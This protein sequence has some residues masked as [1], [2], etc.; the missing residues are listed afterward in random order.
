MRADDLVVLLEIARC[1]SLVG[2]ASALGLNHATV[3]R[4]ISALEA[5]LRT[6]VLV[7]GTHGCELTEVG[8]RLLVSCEQIETALTD[9]RDLVNTIPRD[10]ALSGLVRIATTE[11]F[12]AYFIS[13][14]MAD[15]HRINPDLTVEIITQTRLSA[16]GI[17]ADIEIGVGEPV[18]SRPGAEKLTDY[19]LGLYA[20]AEYEEERG[21][22]ATTTDLR[23][24]SLI[25]YIEGLLRVE[26]LDVLS[27]LIGSRAVTF[28]STSVQVQTAATLA[29]AGI[30]LLPAFVAEREPTL[31]RVLPEHVSITLEFTGCLAP[32]RLRRPASVTVMQAIREMVA[33][34]RADLLPA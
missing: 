16:Y 10:R 32:R 1:G 34:R 15:L 25:Y 12:G 8:E 28:G 31:R 24:H 19:Q 27:R 21:L 4:R 5:E 13:P 11:A 33:E 9:V 14:L 22:P 30:G 6:P 26:D 17:G 29:G 7:R 23:A 18:V 20:S 3:S 2:A